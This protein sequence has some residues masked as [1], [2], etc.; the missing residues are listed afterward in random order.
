MP[1]WCPECNRKYEDAAAADVKGRC[2][3]CEEILEDSDGDEY[4][5]EVDRSDENAVG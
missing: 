1:Y 4:P 3:D 2:E 5:F